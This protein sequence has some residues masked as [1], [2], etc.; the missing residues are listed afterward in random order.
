MTKYHTA[1]L[2]P[3]VVALACVIVA[4]RLMSSHPSP[5]PTS[6][7]PTQ[8]QQPP[9]RRR[10]APSPRSDP[11]FVLP[12]A[13]PP[14]L[15]SSLATT[16]ERRS[17]W[18]INWGESLKAPKPLARQLT[19]SPCKNLE[20]GRRVWS[21]NFDSSCR[22]PT[23]WPTTSTWRMDLSSVMRNVTSVRLRSVGLEKAE[24]P[25]DVWNNRID[26]EIGGTEYGVTV[27]VG[28]Y[29]S[30][31]D[32]ATAVAAA[33]VAAAPALAGFTAT[34]T[35]LTDSLTISESTPTQFT[36]L[37]KSGA[38]ANTSAYRTLG[39]AREDVAST[40]VGGSHDAVAPGR[41]DLEGVLAIDVFA[42]ELSNSLDGPIGR[43]LLKQTVEG[44]PVF[45]ETV[46]DDYHTF[47]PIARLHFLTFRFMVQYGRI[48][49]DETILCDY[50]PYEFHGR[51]NT[52]RLDFGVA[53]YT[54]PMEAEVQL[55]PGT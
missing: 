38:H 21:L 8:M 17:A 50:R 46:I 1:A 32:L 10:H 2:V 24:Y 16:S 19:P 25:V 51:H 53:S 29:A 44:A 37:W 55:D 49:D 54:N 23:A 52:L 11:P 6:S 26:V 14:S 42:D 33:F 45:H 3:A 20:R 47:W 31:G 22:D 43:V 34:Y 9:R 30:G 7:S 41:I 35:S 36:L 48:N 4:W 13:T 12:L 27:P 39:Y 18:G 15:A 28:V 40:L 5:L